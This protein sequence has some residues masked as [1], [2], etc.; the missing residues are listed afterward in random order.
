[1]ATVIE[2]KRGEEPRKHERHAL[3]LVSERPPR[4]GAVAS[5]MLDRRTFYAYNNPNDVAVVLARAVAWADENIVAR[6][7]VRRHEELG[8]S[9]R[10]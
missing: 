10:R 7:Y 3:V 4:E 1:M 2:L 8:S 9:A 5:S 6:V